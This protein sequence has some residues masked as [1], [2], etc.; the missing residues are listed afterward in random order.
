MEL[1]L[2]NVPEASQV[3]SS[4]KPSKRKN[5]GLGGDASQ[6]P[7]VAKF[8]AVSGLSKQL[9]CGQRFESNST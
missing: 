9:L 1:R 7:I 8:G 6:A 3:T 5:S 2:L 4:P